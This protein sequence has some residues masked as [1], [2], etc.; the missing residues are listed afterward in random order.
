MTERRSTEASQFI[1]APREAV[2]Q[3]FVKA[4]ALAQWLAPDTMTGR[5]ETLDARQGGLFRMSLT[6]TEP[7]DANLG[8]SSD[9]TDTFEGKIVELIPNEKIVWVTEFDSDQPD[10]MGEMTIIWTLTDVDG[11]TNVRVVFEDIPK[12]INLADNELGSRQSLKKLAAFVE[13]DSPS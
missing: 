11:G 9:D 12:G 8:K 7:Q 2:Y 13:Y 4:E 10:M 5:V 3:A 6:Y 1:K